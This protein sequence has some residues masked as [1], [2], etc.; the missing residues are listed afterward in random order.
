MTPSQGN[1]FGFAGLL[2]SNTTGQQWIRLIKGWYCGIVMI[3]LSPSWT[4][5]WNHCDHSN[6]PR[7]SL[8]WSVNYAQERQLMWNVLEY[9]DIIMLVQ[10]QLIVCLCRKVSGTRKHNY[11]ETSV[12]CNGNIYGS[13]YNVHTTGTVG[14]DKYD[15]SCHHHKHESPVFVYGW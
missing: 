12:L 14:E 7:H 11:V 10:W 8:Q 9:H 6:A 15:F 1:V 2:W 13:C 3:I 5:A 4:S